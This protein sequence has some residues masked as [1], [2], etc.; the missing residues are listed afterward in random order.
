MGT[1]TCYEI[2]MDCASGK[3]V[4]AWK[5]DNPMSYCDFCLCLGEQMMTYNPKNVHYPA[6]DSSFRS[7]TQLQKKH[8]AK[9]H[10]TNDKPSAEDYI[11][12]QHSR[13]C[14]TNNYKEFARH[15]TS[16]KQ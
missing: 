2:Y 7:V 3:V 4:A 12:A 11:E 9:S 14:C 15:M 6:G 1:A 13:Q 8:C 5:L 10:K 16:C